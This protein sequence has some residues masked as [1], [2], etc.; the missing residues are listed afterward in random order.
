[1]TI[2]QSAPSR[3]RPRP[4]NSGGLGATGQLPILK[5]AKPLSS[6]P[7]LTPIYQSRAA[8]ERLARVDPLA[9]GWKNATPITCRP[10]AY[11]QGSPGRF[12]ESVGHLGVSANLIEAP[13]WGCTAFPPKYSTKYVVTALA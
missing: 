6:V 4:A 11:R 12:V 7:F 5:L 13:P 9:P 1:V 3:A 2:K 10:V 8:P